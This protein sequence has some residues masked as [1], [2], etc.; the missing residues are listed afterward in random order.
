LFRD[1]FHADLQREDEQFRAQW[2]VEQVRP[3]A[4]PPAPGAPVQA[5]AGAGD[6]DARAER[7]RERAAAVAR[8]AARAAARGAAPAPAG[9]A[10]PA[11]APAPAGAAAPAPAGAADVAPAEPLPQAERRGCLIVTADGEVLTPGL[12]IVE[13]T[14]LMMQVRFGEADPAMREVM[15]Q[16]RQ[17]PGQELSM[18]LCSVTEVTYL[19]GTRCSHQAC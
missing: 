3:Q 9:S 10:A 1:R 14:L 19:A 8:D 4:A 7:A 2:A 15:L 18:W 17:T 5:A 12:L 13:M 6:P 11:P 16:K